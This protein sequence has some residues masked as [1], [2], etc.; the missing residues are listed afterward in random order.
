MGNCDLLSGAHE[1]CTAGRAFGNLASLDEA[2]NQLREHRNLPEAHPQQARASEIIRDKR[3][4]KNRS[5][6]FS[7]VASCRVPRKSL[8]VGLSLMSI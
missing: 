1:W 8:Q 4:G 7:K 6:T 3:V 2:L 5:A